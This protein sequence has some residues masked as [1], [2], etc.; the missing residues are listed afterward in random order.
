MPGVNVSPDLSSPAACR[1]VTPN[2]VVKRGLLTTLL[3]VS[4]PAL[5]RHRKRSFSDALSAMAA[6]TAWLRE[7]SQ[8]GVG[9]VMP[10]VDDYVRGDGAEVCAHF[11]R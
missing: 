10:W 4:D 6:L 3:P 2:R 7:V 8:R 1:A 11:P 5:P 9:F